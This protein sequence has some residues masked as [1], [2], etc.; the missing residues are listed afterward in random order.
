MPGVVASAYNPST[1][2]TEAGGPETQGQL[3]LHSKLKTMRAT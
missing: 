2:E 3:Q 1:Q